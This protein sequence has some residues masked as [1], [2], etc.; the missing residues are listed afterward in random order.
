MYAIGTLLAQIIYPLIS[1]KLTR[2]KILT[3][4][5]ITIVIAYLTF[6]FVGFPVF[7]SE[8]VANPK[9]WTIW[10]LYATGVVMFFGQGLVA[11]AVIMQMQST[12]EYNQYKY[13]ERKEAL[14]SSMRALSAKFASAIQRLLIFLTLLLSGLYAISQVISNAEAE[15][16]SGS[17]TSA[18]LVEKI[19]NAR[20]GITNGQWMVF[21]IGMIWVP[22]A[23]LIISLILSMF[24][25]KIDEKK[26]QEIVDAINL[27]QVENHQ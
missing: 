23:L 4:S 1:R 12:I 17:M 24:V 19:D 26:Y 22:L 18:E 2:K 25:F 14:V 8:I 7:G 9:T 20:A 13:G 6:F 3:I 10:I 21:S 5:F 15:L 16:A 27:K 11:V